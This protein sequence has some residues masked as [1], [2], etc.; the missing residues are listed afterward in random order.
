ML[1]PAP[2]GI[3]RHAAISL[4][5]QE[6]N[7]G[8]E[9]NRWNVQIKQVT[10]AFL[11]S[12]VSVVF[13]P[14]RAFS[15][16]HGRRSDHAAVS[17]R[18]PFSVMATVCSKCADREPSTVTIVHLSGSVR[19]IGLPTFTIGSIAM[20][21]AR[22]QLEPALRLAVVGH[23]RL[24][25]ELHPDAVAHQVAHDAEPRLLHHLLHRGADVAQVIA[26]DAPRR[27][28]PPA[29]APSPRAAAPSRR[30]PRP[31]APS[32]PSR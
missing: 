17:T 9:R 19:V 22:H 20:R 31:P 15:C 27:C 4:E 13:R 26:R 10:P 3:A 12:A 32:S 28:P 5:T 2:V 24:L 29:T 16:C 30:P 21:E 1:C 18:F 23:L 14:C 11:R 25:V 7:A 8:N 6:L